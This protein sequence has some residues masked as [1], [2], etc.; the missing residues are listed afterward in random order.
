ML[1]AISVLKSGTLRG[2]AVAAIALAV[3]KLGLTE[4]VPDAGIALDSILAVAQEAVMWGGLVYAAI[5]RTFAPN[6]PL[7][8]TAVAKE[9]E[10]IASRTLEVRK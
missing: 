7:T 5:K 2:L 10:M 4:N 8:E 6:P 3:E 9:Q 1:K